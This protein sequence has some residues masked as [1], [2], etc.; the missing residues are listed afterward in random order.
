MRVGGD[1]LVM[2][3]L[4]ALKATPQVGRIVVVAPPAMHADPAV[5]LADECR[6]DGKRICESLRSGLHDLPPDELVLVAASDLPVLTAQAAADFIERAVRTQADACYGCVERDV[7]TA[8]YPRVP[9]T[10]A[11]LRDGTYCG[12]GLFAL[13]PRI[14]PSLERFIEQLGAA[15]KQPWRLASIFGARV[16][17]KFAFG[18]LTVADAQARASAV[19][20]A[21]VHAVVSPYANVAVNVDRPGDVAL[22]EE[23]LAATESASA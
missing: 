12:A 11:R 22:A 9:H 2:R 21:P 18:R 13:R 7:H 8:A 19:L 17:V 20:G 16:L 3:V 10:W 5:A 15:R 4:R 6:A 23:I 1:A 14:L